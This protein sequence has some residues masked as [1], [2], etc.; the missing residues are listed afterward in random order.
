MNLMDDILKEYLD[1]F[2]IVFLDDILIYSQTIEDHVQ[3]LRRLLDK[4]KQHHLYAKASK[5]L[6]AIENI[7]FWGQMI[8]PKGMYSLDEKLC[9]VKEWDKSRNAKYV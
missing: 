9:A 1:E 6:I 7:E 4:L 5:C 2:V 3:P 8:M